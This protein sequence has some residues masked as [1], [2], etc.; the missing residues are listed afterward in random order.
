MKNRN[1]EWS[2][3]TPIREGS[4]ARTAEDPFKDSAGHRGNAGRR[5]H[6][7][8]NPPL[9]L[10]KTH[11]RIQYVYIYITSQTAWVALF[12]LVQTIGVYNA[13]RNT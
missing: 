13:I 5:M 1:G 11:L 3:G 2:G 9:M 7:Q 4:K 12:M 10:Q 8:D 6:A